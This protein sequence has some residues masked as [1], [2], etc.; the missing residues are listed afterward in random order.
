MQSN[1]FEINTFEELKC[2][3]DQLRMKISMLL[4]EREMT[5]TEIGKHLNI[6]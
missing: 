6:P 2:I 4:I 5:A 1:R 3:S